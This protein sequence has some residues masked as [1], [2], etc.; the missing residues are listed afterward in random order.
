MP[1][2][3]GHAVG[4][5]GSTANMST[6]TTPPATTA[7]AF[8]WTSPPLGASSTASTSPFGGGGQ[9]FPPLASGASPSVGGAELGGGML[10]GGS[11]EPG[12]VFD[13]SEFPS[14]GMGL[15]AVAGANSG[16]SG[17]GVL[18][19]GKALGAPGYSYARRNE[20]S[21]QDFPALGT[22]AAGTSAPA[23]QPPSRPSSAASAGA[24]PP[25]PLTQ[26][27]M[28]GL[29]A[30]IRS[31]KPDLSLLTHGIDL[32]RLGL[33]LNSQ[34]PLYAAFAS[35]F[36]EEGAAA[37]APTESA[38]P[39]SVPACYA[40]ANVSLKP[41]HFKKF[42]VETLVYVFYGFPRDVMQ[43]YAAMELYNRGWRY[44][45][46][47]RTW[48]CRTARSAS[49][50]HAGA[51]N[52]RLEAVENGS[53]GGRLLYFDVNQWDVK[54]FMGTTSPA[55]FM[56]GLLTEAELRDMVAAR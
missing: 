6:G 22:A 15:G 13:L 16:G 41:A 10:G 23:P 56:Q 44:H 52:T 8:P 27:G 30:T 2:A 7:A 14:L 33:N 38:D 11:N 35:P 26:Y 5:R 39:Y 46:D 17:N 55:S 25:P 4:N 20:F 1:P 12:A 43:V 32:T 31:S 49:L 51:V 48:F 50:E 9:A 28:L 37:T 36:M 18:G 21:L 3:G 45:K 42:T 24:P 40:A 54:P 34:E 19:Y 47:L 29:L 53:G